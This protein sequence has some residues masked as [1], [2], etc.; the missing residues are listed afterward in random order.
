MSGIGRKAA[1]L[2][3]RLFDF[4]VAA[5]VRKGRRDYNKFIILGRGRSGSNWLRTLLG[6]HGSVVIFGE[7]FNK[8]GLDQ[9]HIGW[10]V[11]GY[12]T[13]RDLLTLRASDPTTFIREK[14]FAPMP[15]SIDAVGFKLFYHHAQDPD[16]RG[17]W[18]YLKSLDL[19]VI[20][21]ERRNLLASVL[22]GAIAAETNQYSTKS[23]SL[24]QKSETRSLSY[25]ACLGFF[26]QTL[27]WRD[28]YSA[29]FPRTLS[30]YYEDMVDN[31]ELQMQEIQ[32]FLGVSRRPLTSSLRR[33]SKAPMS[34]T[35]RNFDELK[36][37]F[38]GTRYESFFE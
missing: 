27:K 36:A 20:H 29:Y 22:S 19:R 35:I 21:L 11:R 13:T 23:Q 31:C 3:K 14:V 2:R 15:K 8:G 16:M 6:S 7:L 32:D 34:Q 28:E 5:G 9:D 30:V 33:Q 24:E 12:R 10:G 37:R 38:A 26:E 25:E 1:V 4:S 17:I 18:E